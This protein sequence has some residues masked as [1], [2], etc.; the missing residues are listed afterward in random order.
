VAEMDRVETEVRGA[1]ARAFRLSPE[2]A[3]GPL[4]MGYPVAWDSLGH[5]Q[6]VMEIERTFGIRFPTPVI[7]GLRDVRA[8]VEAVKTRQSAGR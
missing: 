8:I 6:L 3:A 5:M 7:A 4:A 2:D 1:I